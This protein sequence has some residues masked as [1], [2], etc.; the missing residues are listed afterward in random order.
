MMVDSVGARAWA[1]VAGSRRGIISAKW[2]DLVDLTIRCPLQI[3]C[4]LWG[5]R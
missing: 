3:Y 4:Q 2:E 5:F 1:T